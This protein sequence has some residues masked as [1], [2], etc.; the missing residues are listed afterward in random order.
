MIIYILE[1]IVLINEIISK[2]KTLYPKIILFDE[3]E[4]NTIHFGST[5]KNIILSH[6]SFS[7]IIGYLAFN[8]N[9]YFPNKGTMWSPIGIFLNKGFIP[10]IC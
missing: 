6:G 9:V 10:I 5:C 1:Q 4:V 7:A 2:L 3:D 8:S